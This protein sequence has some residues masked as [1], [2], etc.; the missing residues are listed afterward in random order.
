MTEFWENS[1]RDKQ[2]MWGWEPADSAISTLELF[3]KYGLTNIL[4]PGYGYGRN[5]RVFI[6]EG[7]KVTG[8]EV[9][10]TAVDIS[11]QHFGD[12]VK[13]YHG[14]VGSMPFD[15]ELYDGIFCYALIHLLNTEERTKLIDN[16]YDQLKPG[17]YMVFV[18]IAKTDFRYGRG[19]EI[20]QDTF[21]TFPGVNLFFYDSD[22]IKSAF[23]KYGLI[24]AEIT[25]EP[26]INSGDKP[27]QRFWSIV[28]KKES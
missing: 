5:A 25:N 19:T 28:C 11:K 17:G 22:S 1:F 26:M 9:S 12:Q 21:S 20:G 6:N 8:I 7:F 18:S 16:C 23:G 10:Q 3:R 24:S 2:E 27:S 4:I 14:S 13:I 15:Q